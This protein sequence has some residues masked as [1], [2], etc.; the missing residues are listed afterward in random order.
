M[1]YGGKPMLV[2]KTQLSIGGTMS[3][4][5]ADAFTNEEIVLPRDLD[6]GRGVVLKYLVVECTNYDALFVNGEDVM[7]FLSEVEVTSEVYP[8]NAD[9]ICKKHMRSLLGAAS[10]HCLI[11]QTWSFKLWWPTLRSKIYLC[12]HNDT[13]ATAMTWAYRL[14]Y[15]IAKFS[16]NEKTAMLA[17][18]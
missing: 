4:A 12:I 5:A 3:A 15:S 16:N 1:P 9:L 18:D 11:E 8:N 10:S 6:N 13:A 2:Q 17:A 14:F 7:I